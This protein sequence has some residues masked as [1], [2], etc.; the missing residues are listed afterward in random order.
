MPDG[1]R[2][3]IFWVVLTIVRITLVFNFIFLLGVFFYVVA[4]F[5]PRS[6]VVRTGPYIYQPQPGQPQPQPGQ[7]VFYPPNPGNQYPPPVTLD[8]QLVADF[9]D[10]I[11]AGKLDDI[12][13]M[14]Q[15]N[16][17]LINATLSTNGY[18]PIHTAVEADQIDV[19]KLLLQKGASADD[20]GLMINAAMTG[21]D[22]IIALL[23]DHN[24]DINS[25]ADPKDLAAM[26]PI[27]A[28]ELYGHLDTAKFLYQNGARIDFFSA[29]GLGM[30]DYVTDQLKKD[31]TLATLK[32]DWGDE[33]IWIA[34]NTGQTDV[35]KLLLTY[36]GS[37][38]GTYGGPK[39]T[40][41]HIAAERDYED[42]ALL[43]INNGV[44]INAK[45]QNGETP[46]DY[47]LD[48]DQIAMAGLL[49]KHGAQ[50]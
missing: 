46:L 23:L 34:V 25:E 5:H 18:S 49:R 17:D 48:N 15:Q 47:A 36:G 4:H 42:L 13:S 7:P 2:R 10:A 38:A 8:P 12:Q 31:P 20:P 43:L 9:H 28:A 39:F 6:N 19:V 40:A 14:L 21:D 41:L 32:D 29:A 50:R 26:T 30:T 27:R 44:D 11:T 16:P 3:K 24:A 45:D 35:V 1:S 33:A 37:Y 22:D